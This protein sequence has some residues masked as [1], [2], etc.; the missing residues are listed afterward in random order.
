MKGKE[1]HAAF[2]PKDAPQETE[3]IPAVTLQAGE[4]WLDVYRAAAEE[5]VIVVGGSAQTVGAAGGYL[6]GGGH[7]AFSHF[8]GLAVDNLL[9]VN[10]VDAKGERRTLN[11]YTD[12]EY[13]YAL[14][15]GGGCAW[16]IIT[17]VTYKTHP[18]PSHIQVG[19]L[20]FNVTNNSTLRAVLEKSLRGLVS[21]TDAGY[22]G[23]G[24]INTSDEPLGFNA[25][26]IQPNGTNATFNTAFKP[27]YDIS[28]MQGV[29][30]LV[31]NAEFPSWIEYSKYFLRDPNIATNIIEASRLLT[32]EVLLHR[33]GDLVDLAF[34]YPSPG[35]GFSFIGKVD[36]TERDNTAAH[37]IWKESRALLGWSANWTDDAPVDEKRK[38]KLDLVEISRRLGEIVGPEGGSYEPD[39]K[40]VFWGDKYDR[41]LATK[42]RVDPTNLF[43]C[44]RCVGTDIILE[45]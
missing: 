20:Q 11:Q 41:L 44:N 42:R 18:N 40:N 30:G 12:P 39:W 34:E 19:F 14:R 28:T 37:S 13:F 1:W 38:A 22:T 15:G 36:A 21:V 7:S 17:S 16:G 25:I 9:E 10:L 26:F 24:I 4:Q 43:V 3:G 8:Y 27:Y 23:Y 6:T 45:P 33:T 35:P 2:V 32:Q 5:G 31:A 29:S